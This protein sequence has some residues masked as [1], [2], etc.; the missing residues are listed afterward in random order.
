MQQPQLK[1]E[2]KPI[3]V[4]VYDQIGAK[5]AP[6]LQEAGLELDPMQVQERVQRQVYARWGTNAEMIQDRH[7]VGWLVDVSDAFNSME[8]YAVVRN[9]HGTRMAL[10]VVDQEEVDE[11]K[12]SGEWKTE[13]AQGLDPEITKAMAEIEGSPPAAPGRPGKPVAPQQQVQAPAQAKE[14]D[15]EDPRLLVWWEPQSDGK[16]NRAMAPSVEHTTYGEAQQ[17][18][19]QLLMKGASVEVWEG[20]KE[21]KIEVSL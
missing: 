20:R 19:L 15:P 3:D 1:E 4:V 10:A 21:P 14:P 16:P 8:L 13:D 5:L 9:V 11:F 18:V 2:E 12:K 6:F 17:R 7:G